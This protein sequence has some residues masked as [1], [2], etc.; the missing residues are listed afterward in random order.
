MVAQVTQEFL[1]GVQKARLARLREMLVKHNCAAGLF[2]DPCHVRYATDASNMTIWHK[3]NQIRYL[4][5]PASDADP[6]TLWES[7]FVDVSGMKKLMGHTID[8]WVPNIPINICSVGDNVVEKV[9]EWA[10]DLDEHLR[11]VCAAAGNW[12]VAVQGG[13]PLQAFALEKKGYQL[14]SGSQVI[15]HARARKVKHE[16]ELV[17]CGVQTTCDAMNYLHSHLAPGISENALWAKLHEYNIAVGG[18]YVET[19]LL[20]SGARTSPWMQES[21]T[22]L[23]DPG[24]L[25]ALDSDCTGPFGYFIDVSRTWHVP[26]EHYTDS[27]RKKFRKQQELHKYA[28]EMLAHNMALVKPGMGFR[29]AAEKAWPIPD[30]FLSRRY[31]IMAHG[32]GINGEYPY[33]YHTVD[34][35]SCGY[36]GVVEEG[37]TL[38]FEAF[39]AEDDE[40]GVKCE[41]H[42]VIGADGVE[43]LSHMLD[44]CPYLEGREL[45]W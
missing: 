37:M 8:K 12:R 5:V 34:W 40:D 2:H 1:P 32:N 14:Q 26:R 38:S 31:G 28:R 3:R 6:V 25:V 45:P 19:R 43:N 20:N 4:M 29:E 42:C 44:F 23:V 15:E 16:I 7:M 13:D 10:S 36:D 22:K 41:E 24:D 35:P 11:P 9:E 21:S 33:I 17:K 18:E 30:R 39:I 27:E